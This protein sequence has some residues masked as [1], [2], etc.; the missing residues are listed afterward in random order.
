M[1][2]IIINAETEKEIAF[3][4]DLLLKNNIKA[5]I[6]REEELEDYGLLK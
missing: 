2:T 5:K 3:F 4:S 1:N 6:L